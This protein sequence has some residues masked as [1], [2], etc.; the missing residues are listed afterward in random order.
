[1]I[2]LTLTTDR[3]EHAIELLS[4]SLA[5]V[6]Y[7]NTWQA[8]TSELNRRQLGAPARPIMIARRYVVRLPVAVKDALKIG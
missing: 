5:E 7:P 1:M 4:K 2:T 8:L 6:W 3:L